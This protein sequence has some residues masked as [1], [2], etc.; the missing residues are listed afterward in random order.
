MAPATRGC[1]HH[2][3]RAILPIL[4]AAVALSACS[5]KFNWRDYRSSDAPYAVLFPAKPSLQTRAVDLDG[6]QVRM[7]M[8]AAEI[9]GTM[10]AVGSAELADAAR[11]QAAVDAMKTAMLRNIG[12]TTATE[13]ARDGEMDV[14]AHGA[15]SGR[16]LQL[17]GRFLAR[18]KHVFQA[19]VI[20]PDQGVDA[21]Q[22]DM[23]LRSLKVN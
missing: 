2:S 15:S 12:S 20:G 6:Q 16:A 23:F 22:V 18:G 10:F 8:A 9:D 4:A 3:M 7:T 13:K 21:E 19:V 14:E 1:Y 11:A 17:H 5:P